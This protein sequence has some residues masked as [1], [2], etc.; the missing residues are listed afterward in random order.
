MCDQAA[1]AFFFEKKNGRAQ[2]AGAFFCQIYHFWIKAIF[3]A[4]RRPQA[5][6]FVAVKNDIMDIYGLGVPEGI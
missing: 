6:F 5:P 1:G 3:V 4:L 2:A